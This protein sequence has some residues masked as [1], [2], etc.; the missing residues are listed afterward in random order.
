MEHTTMNDKKCV[1]KDASLA[2]IRGT[3]KW[4]G[5]K[6]NLAFLKNDSDS[7]ENVVGVSTGVVSFFFRWRSGLAITLDAPN[8]NDKLYQI[9]FLIEFLC[10][11]L[12]N[13]KFIE[14]RNSDIF[15]IYKTHISAP[16]NLPPRTETTIPPPGP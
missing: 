16:W 9:K 10:I 5:S 13:L 4:N 7:T 8:R 1:L 2:A 15:L 3:V 14:G 12:N 6:F 11:W